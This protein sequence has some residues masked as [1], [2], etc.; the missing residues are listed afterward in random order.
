M[1]HHREEED[2]DRF[3]TTRGGS[4]YYWRRVPKNLIGIDP[5]GARI[6]TALKTKNR[7]RARAKRDHLEAADNEYWS[8]LLS[9]DAGAWARYQA[10]VKRAE[11]LGFAYKSADVVASEKL[12]SIVERIESI[13]D[14]RTPDLA[15]NAALG[16]AAFPEITVTAA[17][18]VYIEEIMRA[19][20]R[21]KSPEQYKRWK[22]KKEAS[23][24]TFNEVIGE[25]KAMQAITRDDALK[26]HAFWLKRVALAALRSW[27]P[28]ADSEPT[29]WHRHPKTGRR[30]EN[31]NPAREYIAW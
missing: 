23:V 29:G 7:G 24:R 1:G 20:T 22:Q 18:K 8:S 9:G 14:A 31:G 10:T 19:E 13:M 12:S 30:R 26:F 16:G 25:D 6:R 3:L 5:R 15:I 17:M 4:F 11:A 27:D 2:P 28:V 21:T